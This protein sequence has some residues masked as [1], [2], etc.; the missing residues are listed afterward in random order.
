[1][2]A[3]RAQAST[4]PFFA[5]SSSTIDWVSGCIRML[6]SATAVRLVSAFSETSTIRTSPRSSTWVSSSRYA[7]R[8]A[9]LSIAGSFGRCSFSQL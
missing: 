2:P 5:R 3:T 6:A 9:L 4:S 7:S 1:M 8:G